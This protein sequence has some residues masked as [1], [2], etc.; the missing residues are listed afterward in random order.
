MSV[1]G[2]G[3]RGR[4]VLLAAM[5]AAGISLWFAAAPV[6]GRVVGRVMGSGEALARGVALVPEVGVV[7]VDLAPVL[8]FAPFGRA[9]G[10]APQQVR[11][12]AELGLQLLG[13]TVAVPEAGSRAIIA[14]GD[15]P[16]ASY[17]V[18]GE[19][20]AGV[21][22]RAVF[23]DRAVVVVDGQDVAL[24]FAGSEP[25]AAAVVA[26]AD[27]NSVGG[28]DLMNLLAGNV[29]A[30]E[31]EVLPGETWLARLRAEMVADAPG[32][33]RRLG[34]E[35][36]D[37]GY[38]VTAAAPPEVLA[39]GL[40]PGDVVSAV[41][42]TELAGLTPDAALFDMVANAGRAS[43]AVLRDGKMITRTYPLQ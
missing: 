4:L 9:E 6:V 22:L 2:S 39:A 13:I 3:G 43:V 34:L 38:L 7:R 1:W 42:G 18:G 33:L 16:V 5:L 25:V 40:R 24:A 31:T 8:E 17:P 41:N 23:A 28:V 10:E 36:A 37:Q 14:G 26:D 19:I 11:R 30:P 15:L 32:L 20:R 12:E 29:P 35:A 27:G 21:V